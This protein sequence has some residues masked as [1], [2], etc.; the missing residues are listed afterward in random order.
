MR[1]QSMYCLECVCGQPIETHTPVC[2]CPKC[3][4]LIEI[5]REEAK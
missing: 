2:K 1:E 5:R 4:R 3:G